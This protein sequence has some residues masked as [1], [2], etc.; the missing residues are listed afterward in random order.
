MPTRRA[1]VSNPIVEYQQ[2]FVTCGNLVEI[3]QQQAL[4]HMYH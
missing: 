4:V 1:Q 2:V 3:A